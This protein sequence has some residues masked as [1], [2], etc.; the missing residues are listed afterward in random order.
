MGRRP[1][2]R[3]DDAFDSL[4]GAQPSYV[5]VR[6]VRGTVDAHFAESERSG[7]VEYYDFD[8]VCAFE[9]EIGTA[10]GRNGG[11]GTLACVA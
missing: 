9:S 10:V 6:I 7:L 1:R 5:I 2:Q 8:V 4:F 3:T 11:D